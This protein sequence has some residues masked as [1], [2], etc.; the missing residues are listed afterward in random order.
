ML[1][2]QPEKGRRNTLDN[3]IDRAQNSRMQKEAHLDRLDERTHLRSVSTALALASSR[4]YARE[5]IFSVARR[6]PSTIDHVSRKKPA[7]VKSIAISSFD[8]RTCSSLLLLVDAGIWTTSSSLEHQ[9]L[10][11]Y[12]GLH[13]GSQTFAIADCCLDTQ[14]DF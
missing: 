7:T 11:F 2:P 13:V 1:K 14:P 10:L 8:L 4:T 5:A 12:N 9:L 6:R 3:P